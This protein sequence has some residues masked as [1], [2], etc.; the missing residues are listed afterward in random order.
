MLVKSYLQNKQT[1]NKSDLVVHVCYPSYSGG[2]S[3][4][5]LVQVLP[6]Q[7]PETKFKNKLKQKYSVAQVAQHLPNKHE[8]LS[9]NPSIGKQQKILL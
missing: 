7:K 6:E 1:K 5:I 8:A 9:L 4:R 3:R 2:R